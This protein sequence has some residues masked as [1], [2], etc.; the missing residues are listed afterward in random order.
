MMFLSAESS[1]VCEISEP[2]PPARPS[3]PAPKEARILSRERAGKSHDR[4]L[5]AD[6]TNVRPEVS[7]RAEFTPLPRRLSGLDPHSVERPPD[8]RHASHEKGRRQHMRQ[9]GSRLGREIHAE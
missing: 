4:A 3:L 6:F 7:L 8:E 5:C 9:D 1:S 2:T